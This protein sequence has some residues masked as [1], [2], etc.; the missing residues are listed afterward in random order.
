MMIPLFVRSSKLFD[1]H[2]LFRKVQCGNVVTSKYQ[3]FVNV[4]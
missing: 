1:L 3:L 2:F 4:V